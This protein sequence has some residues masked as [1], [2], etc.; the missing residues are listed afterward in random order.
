MRKYVEGSGYIDRQDWK[1]RDVIN[2]LR[3]LKNPEKIIYDVPANVDSIYRKHR[4]ISINLAVNIEVLHTILKFL[5]NE[6]VK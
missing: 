6:N 1:D 2:L 3:R 5:T 4:N